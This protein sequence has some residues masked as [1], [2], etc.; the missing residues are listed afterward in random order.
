MNAGKLPTIH[1][2]RSFFAPDELILEFREL[3]EEKI[4]LDYITFSGSGEP[5]LNSDIGYLIKEMKKLSSFPVAVL[6]NGTLLHRTD[7]QK[8]LLE[9]DLLLLHWMPYLKMYLQK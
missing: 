8:D 5:T 7:V 4:H 1:Q 2:R 9:A 3:M 6:T